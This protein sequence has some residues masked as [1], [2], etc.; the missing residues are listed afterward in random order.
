MLTTPTSWAAFFR[1]TATLEQDPATALASFQAIR[2]IIPY[3]DT[4]PWTA[5]AQFIEKAPHI[6]FLC[7]QQQ[8]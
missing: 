1:N 6:P 5:I 4:T 3:D 8:Q 2:L 7:L